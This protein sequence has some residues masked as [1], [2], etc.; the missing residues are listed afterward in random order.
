MTNRMQLISKSKELI[1]RLKKTES[2]R[3]KSFLL[4]ALTIGSLETLN[5]HYRDN[6]DLLLNNDDE[7]FD[8]IGIPKHLREW[9]YDF[10]ELQGSLSH[11]ELMKLD[12]LIRERDV[13]FVAI[14]EIKEM[15]KEG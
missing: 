12:R 3:Q 5:N 13:H 1:E 9:I 8:L 2:E 4:R 10:V 14:D 6:G 7:L 11:V 15:I